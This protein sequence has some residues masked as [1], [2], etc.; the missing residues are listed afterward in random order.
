MYTD[1][2]SVQAVRVTYGCEIVTIRIP[3]G[4]NIGNFFM[5]DM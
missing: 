4:Y 1:R 5:N 2:E 3:T